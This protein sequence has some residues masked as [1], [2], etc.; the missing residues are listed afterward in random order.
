MPRASAGVEAPAGTVR[1]SSHTHPLR[2]YRH[3]VI[4]PAIHRSDATDL[5]P[6]GGHESRRDRDHLLWRSTWRRRHQHHARLYHRRWHT[7]ADTTL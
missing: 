3:T 4:P 1:R 5:V 7:Y 6:L 2:P